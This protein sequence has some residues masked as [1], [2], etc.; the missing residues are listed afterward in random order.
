[1][2][3]IDRNTLAEVHRFWFG[4]LKSPGEPPPQA[5]MDR[6]FSA[7]PEFDA[8][9]KEKWERY[10]DPA[11]AREW[12]YGAL[13][14]I[15]QVG[16]VILLDQFPRNIYRTTHHAY[17]YDEKVRSVAR[18]IL[19]PGGLEAFFPVERAFVALPF[20]HSESLV[21][22]DLSMAYLAE[23]MMLTPPEAR[24]GPRTGMDFAYKHWDIV[25]KFGRFPHRN[26][27]MGRESTPEEL[28]FLKSGRGF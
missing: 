6:W 4:E 26:V 17:D 18:A 5:T 3:D 21:D 10:L 11:K 9:V 14:R 15:E 1:V 27:M 2:T 16:L 19:K 28:E 25:K 24:A 23:I 7:K 12:D 8:E 22:Q 20:M 13:S